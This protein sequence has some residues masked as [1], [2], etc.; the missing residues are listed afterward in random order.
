MAFHEKKIT[1]KEILLSLELKLN[2]SRANYFLLSHGPPNLMADYGFLL[3]QGYRTPWSC[4]LFTDP[5]P[6]TYSWLRLT[7]LI[8]LLLLSLILLFTPF[9]TIFDPVF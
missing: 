8:R 2:M 3:E 6:L 1:Q 5:T 7:F 9:L 4:V